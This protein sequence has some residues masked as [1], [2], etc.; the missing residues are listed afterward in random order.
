MTTEQRLGLLIAQVGADVK[1]LSNI[2]AVLTYA[3]TVN[4][5]FS[6]SNFN[7]LTLTGNVTFTTSNRALTRSE[8]V[9]IIN[10]ATARTFTFPSGWVWIGA[11]APN[12]I[13]ASKTGVLS[14][15][16]FGT[17]DT[18]IIASYAVQL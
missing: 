6:V 10:G 13:A 14:L 4:L 16:C 15:F 9:R 5:D 7:T 2:H 18:D 17:A 3:A 11:A 12:G 1:A 8:V